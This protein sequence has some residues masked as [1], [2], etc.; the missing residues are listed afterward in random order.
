MVDIV[1]DPTIPTAPILHLLCGKIASGKSTLAAQLATQ[2]GTIIISEDRWLS[3]LYGD[4]MHSVADYARCAEKLKNAMKPHLITLLTAGISIVLDFPANTLASREW[5]MS[6]ITA[7]GADNRLHY[8][9][10]ADEVCKAR[11]HTRNEAGEHDFSATDE[12]FTI[13]SRYFVE[14]Q[15]AEG[16]TLVVHE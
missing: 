5:M 4:E 2:A 1:N 12:Q 11:L 10:V 13:I 8:L 15:E 6:I 16:F 3:E 7:T 14:P 9:N